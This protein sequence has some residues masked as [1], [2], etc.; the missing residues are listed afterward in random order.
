MINKSIEKPHVQIR[1]N[2]CFEGTDDDLK[3]R[4][5]AYF[6]R[7]YV[8]PTENE[9]LQLMLQGASH[10]AYV[11]HD[12]DDK[13]PHCHIILIFKYNRT[14]T[15]LAKEL[16]RID[17]KQNW[18]FSI[19]HDKYHAFDYLH[20][21]DV[22]SVESGKYLYPE[23]EVFTEDVA[24]FT[25]GGSH[26]R[27]SLAFYN[28]LVENNLS[29]VEMARKYGRDYLKNIAKYDEAKEILQREIHNSNEPNFEGINALPCSYWSEPL[30]TDLCLSLIVALKNNDV[31]FNHLSNDDIDRIIRD[32]CT[33]YA[34]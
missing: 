31:K 14:P 17:N 10:W 22:K 1:P 18:H 25:R 23:R 27:D 24:F 19:L 33:M 9:L 29:R 32:T 15:A 12:K 2:V 20:H 11:W 4:A 3:E 7:G 34:Q 5:Y 16:C 30:A 21:R 28:D 26:A 6:I 13:A 8:K